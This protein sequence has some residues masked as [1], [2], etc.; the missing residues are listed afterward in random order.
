MPLFRHPSSL[1]LPV[2]ALLATACGGA[3]AQSAN[4]IQLTSSRDSLRADGYSQA[5]I[6]A[7]VRDRSGNL[8]PDGTEVRFTTT[9]GTIDP[10]AMTQAGRARVNLTSAAAPGIAEISANSG[11]A[12][13]PYR[14]LFLSEGQRGPERPNVIPIIAEYIAYSADMHI[15]EATGHVTI[16]LGSATILADQAQLNVDQNVLVAESAAGSP[17]LTITDGKTT[18]IAQRMRYEWPLSRGVMD[19]NGELYEFLGPPLLLG[20]KQTDPL[21]PNTFQ[22][23]DLEDTLMWVTAKRAA[24]FPNQRIHFRKAELRPAGKKVLSLPY[25]T[26][27]LSSSLN[28]TDQY[29]GLGTQGVLVDLPYYL[30]LTDHTSTSLRFGWNQLEGSYSAYKPGFGLDLRHRIFVGENGEDTVNLSRITSSDWG[31]WYRHNRNWSSTVQT[32]GYAEF[33]DHRN[34][35]ATG[36][37]YWQAKTFNAALNLSTNRIQGFGSSYSSSVNLETHAKP[38]GIYG[39]MYSFIST[40]GISEGTF[41]DFRQALQMRATLP[42][43]R[44]S[45]RTLSTATFTGGRILAGQL[46]GPTA[47][48]IY[49]V[50]H[51]FGKQTYLS[52]NY[53]YLYRPGFSNLV[54]KHRVGLTF[55]TSTQKFSFFTSATQTLDGRST[56]MTNDLTYDLTPK[57][58][59]GLRNIYFLSVHIPYSDEEISLTYPL[60]NRPFTLFWSK[61]Y[62]RFQVEVAQLAF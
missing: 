25:Q 50:N 10:L 2:L 27:T 15:I 19:Q 61:Q 31:A 32:N 43:W 59:L 60:L 29:L 47:D 55:G 26:T 5:V 33:P 45:K 51:R 49:S 21:Q 3:Y 41:H 8:V 53:S 22:M 13:R 34:L 42:T 14:V 30:N 12:F 1:V 4:T 62:H 17:G 23:V 36:N 54:S 11:Q 58:R 35:F 28:E 37:T 57:L 48:A 18:W 16:R 7:E 44:W 46:K 38:V 40:T 9:L 39:M 52:G 20:K 56:S 24:L 6:T